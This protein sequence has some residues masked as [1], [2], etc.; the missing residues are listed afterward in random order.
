[1]PSRARSRSC[2]RFHPAF[3]TPI[4]GTFKLPRLIIACSDGKIFLCAR[5]PVAPKKTKASDGMCSPL[6]LACAVEDGAGVCGTELMQIL[7]HS[8]KVGRMGFRRRLI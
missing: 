4:T 3:A 2:S 8:K 5:S 6:F 7:L 1:M